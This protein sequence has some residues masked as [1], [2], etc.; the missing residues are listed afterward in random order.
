VFIKTDASHVPEEVERTLADRTAFRLL[1]LTTVALLA[2]APA[3]AKAPPRVRGFV[4]GVNSDSIIVKER[5]GS[6][7]TLNT[8][9]YTSYANVA[10]SS[11]DAIQVN[12]FVGSA[13]KGPLSSMVAVELAIIPENM[14]AGRISL[15]GWDPLPDP[16]GRGLA[17]FLAT[18]NR[19]KV[20]PDLLVEVL[21]MHAAMAPE[22]RPVFEARTF[23]LFAVRKRGRRVTTELG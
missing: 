7:V 23:H 1:L 14:R 11:L 9:P 3:Y 12:D 22:D 8:G 21:Q 17:D 13:V 16:G 10:P 6:V 15:Y 2:A 20:T 5:D 19:T 4:T 18:V